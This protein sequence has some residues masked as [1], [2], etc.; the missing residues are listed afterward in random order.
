MAQIMYN[1]KVSKYQPL[2]DK[3]KKRGLLQ[4]RRFV[5]L[6]FESTGYA[7][8]NV[9]ALFKKWTKLAK[10]RLGP[11]RFDEVC[12]GSSTRRTCS[13]VIHFWNAISVIARVGCRNLTL[14]AERS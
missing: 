14:C 10:Q 7:K 9:R 12:E 5:P 4:Q 13:T 11:E 1:K 8:G 2:A 6:V 3:L